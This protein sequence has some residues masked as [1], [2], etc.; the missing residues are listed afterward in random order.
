MSSWFYHAV[1]ELSINGVR[2]RKTPRDFCAE[3]FSPRARASKEFDSRKSRAR[4]LQ[5]SGSSERAW[6]SARD[7]ARAGGSFK[8]SGDRGLVFTW[9]GCSWSPAE[10]GGRSKLPVP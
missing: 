6:G 9:H 2:A 1:L 5:P 8:N 10:R 4:I 3:I 7:V